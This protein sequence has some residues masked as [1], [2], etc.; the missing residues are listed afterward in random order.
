PDIPTTLTNIVI[1][2]VNVTESVDQLGEEAITDAS[3]APGAL[4]AGHFDSGVFKAILDFP[5]SGLNQSNTSGFAT[6]LL[7]ILDRMEAFLGLTG[8]TTGRWISNEGL[9]EDLS[10][11]GYGRIYNLLFA[12]ALGQ[13]PGSMGMP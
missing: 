10:H 9:N 12:I 5:R 6:S 4:T 1:P 3:I 11:M 7:Y 8:A 2:L 13:T